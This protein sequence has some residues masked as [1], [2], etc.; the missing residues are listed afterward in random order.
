MDR[1]SGLLTNLRIRTKLAVLVVTVSAVGAG[2]GLWNLSN[3]R[4]AAGAFRVTSRENL[5]A[6]AALVEADRDVLQAMV[7]ERS[8]MFLRQASD[9][10]AAMR[11]QHEEEPPSGAR[12]LAEVHGHPHDRGPATGRRGLRAGPRGLGE[13]VPRGG[14]PHRP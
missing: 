9:E 3:F 12:A 1:R 13:D 4:W 6:V 10:A 8:L 7:A 11:K 14:R 5:P 2:I